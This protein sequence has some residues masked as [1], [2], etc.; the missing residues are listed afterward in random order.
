[1]KALSVVLFV[2][3]IFLQIENAFSQTSERDIGNLTL[4]GKTF[5]LNGERIKRAELANRLGSDTEAYGYLSKARTFRTLSDLSL[6]PG[7]FLIVN[8]TTN[9][10]LGNEMNW[11]IFGAGVGLFIPSIFF[12]R[13]YRKNAGMTVGSYNSYRGS[14][15]YKKEIRFGVTDHGIGL[16]YSF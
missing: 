13:A 8:P 2:C 11:M 12:E 7:L 14:G 10:I 9:A 4:T 15:A 1:M 16:Q 6:F 5:Y 3:T